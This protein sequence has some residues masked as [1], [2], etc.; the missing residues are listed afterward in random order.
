ERFVGDGA[1]VALSASQSGSRLYHTGAVT[2]N[3]A[4]AIG[5]RV[6]GGVTVA[7]EGVKVLARGVD[8]HWT[9]S[10]DSSGELLHR[11]GWRQESAHAPLRETLAAALLMLCEWDPATPLVDPMC[12]AGTVPLE[13]CALAMRVAPGLARGFAFE[14]WPAHD[15]ARLAAARAQAEAARL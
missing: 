8:D 10:V 11:R 6:R 15:P 7:A 2:E 14:R 12:G 3:L 13:A 1:A 4:A 5:D 9:L